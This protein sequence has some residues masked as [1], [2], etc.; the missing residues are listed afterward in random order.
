MGQS[1]YTFPYTEPTLNFSLMGNK[2]AG[3]NAIADANSVMAPVALAPS[4]TP[5]QTPVTDATNASFTGAFK[6][7]AFGAI[8]DAA[9]TYGAGSGGW[10]QSLSNWGKE[11]G[12]FTQVDKNGMK[13]T[14]LLDYG[15]GLGQGLL[16]TKMGLD[17][18][19]L[20]KQSQQSQQEQF[21]TNHNNQ[22]K[23]TNAE[24]TARRERQLSATDPNLS[25]D[26]R[27]QKVAEYMSKWG[28]S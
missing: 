20:A 26:Q 19:N 16:N 6:P 4:A 5:F 14:G 24:L 15:I 12:M 22:V 17:Y 2:W 21:W 1:N 18:L 8:G 3:R 25:A 28:V 13:T 23:T 10:L 7:E 27:N 9:K 11:N